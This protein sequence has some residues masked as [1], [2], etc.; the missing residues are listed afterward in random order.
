[1][2]N[3]KNTKN[4]GN[5][6]KHKMS[7]GDKPK[8]FWGTIKRLIKYVSDY[9]K[10]IIT[11]VIMLIL[12]V[13]L[14]VST[15]KILGKATTELGNNI[16]QKMTYTEIQKQ[17]VNLPQQIKHAIP[18]DA[19]VQ[20]LI[21]NNMIPKDIAAKIPEIA[22]SVSISNEPQ[23]N[24][25]YIGKI[26]LIV[27][28]ICIISAICTYVA[29]RT[30]AYISQ[31]V[32]YDLRKK[33]DQ[34]F[35]KL[36]LKFF[37]KHTHG[38]ILSRVTN[39]IDNVG[40]MLQQTLVQVLQS[41]FTV[42]G[43]LILMFTINIKLTLIALLVVPVGGICVSLIVKNSQKYFMAQQKVLGLVDSQIEETY[44]GDIVVKSFNMQNKKIQDFSDENEKLYESGWKSQF[45]S[46]LTMPVMNAITNLGYVSICILGAKLIIDGKISIGDIQ[47]FLQYS[48][49]FNQPIVQ[50]A[51]IMNLI[52]STVASAERVFE[53]LDEKEEIPE[54]KNPIKLSEFKDSIEFKNISFRYEE[55]EPLIE[56]W[57]MKIKK[58]QTVA[59]V[60]PTGAGKT[61]I[62][63]LLMRFY[64]IQSGDILID[65]VSIKDMTRDNLRSLIAMV[66]QDTWL[67]NGTIN[68]NLKYAKPDSTDEEIQKAADMAYADHF[69]RA[70]P[71]GYNFELNEE[72]NNVSQGQ[73]Q[74]LTIARAVLADRPILVL[75]EA[76]SN[77]DTRTELLLQ[78]AMNKLMNKTTSF[79]IA[80]RLSTIKNA[81]MILV[82]QH[83]RI[84]ERGKHDELIAK[85]GEYAKLYN[86]QFN[87]E[88]V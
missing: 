53:I 9:K 78:K 56:D 39:D 33:V 40:S 66:L 8:D 77:V 30:M 37:D 5:G 52:Q 26:L 57:S 67:F 7:V 49:Q 48:H 2:E 1:M 50:T 72:A 60:G 24:F 23:I 38:E 15:P 85:N 47:A 63:N 62:V 83:G 46:G 41:V 64:D 51:N 27:L 54:C 87:E 19:T 22:K 86:S 70:L 43:I 84:V 25:T 21:D 45:F 3:N 75:D 29:N 32:T 80:H 65:G 28:G 88:T 36:P 71:N 76:T 81:D 68:E 17:M 42:I 74:L 82:M 61:T 73:K 20:T 13:V 11:V 6:P 4:F 55:N 10:A 16:M 69:I 31:K 59:I 14:S 79:V 58:G 34:K 44:S 35:D 18:K 12:G